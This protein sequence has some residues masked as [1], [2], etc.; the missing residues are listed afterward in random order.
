MA[1]VRLTPAPLALVESPGIVNAII[2]PALEIF[3]QSIVL[4]SAGLLT[5]LCISRAQWGVGPFAVLWCH[6]IWKQE[7]I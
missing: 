2:F 7:R 4:I 5:V 3:K 1:E 6:E